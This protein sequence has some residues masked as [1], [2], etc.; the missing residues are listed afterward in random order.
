MVL[1][2]PGS[3]DESMFPDEGTGAFS[4]G[5]GT[6]TIRTAPLSPHTT[7][8]LTCRNDFTTRSRLTQ[9]MIGIFFCAP[10]G[11]HYDCRWWRGPVLSET[12]VPPPR[13]DQQYF[14]G[15]RDPL[16]SIRVE[17]GWC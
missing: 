14:L 7:A 12:A 9:V 4:K 8:A 3:R 6:V 10:P 17:A 11:W 5:R 16:T 2:D 15:L 1:L 13:F